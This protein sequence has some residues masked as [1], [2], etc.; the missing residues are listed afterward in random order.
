MQKH[1]PYSLILTSKILM[2]KTTYS[3]HSRQYLLSLKKESGHSDGLTKSAHL[4]LR[5]WL[6]LLLLKESFSQVH[7]VQSSG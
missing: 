3:R 5:D 2:R 1:I 6:H 4:S 7:S